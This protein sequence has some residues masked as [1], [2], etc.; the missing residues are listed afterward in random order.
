MY[1]KAR[2]TNLPVGRQARTSGVL[3]Q[4]S[5]LRAQKE[6]RGDGRDERCLGL[7]A[8]GSEK[9]RGEWRDERLR[10]A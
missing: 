7:S 8:Q 9:K 3:A 2:V 4:C 10:R 5:E 1:N 6:K